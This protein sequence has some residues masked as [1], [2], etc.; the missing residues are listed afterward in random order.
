MTERQQSI[1]SISSILGWIAY[2]GLF[3]YF[4]ISYSWLY[5]VLGFIF[6]AISTGI[7]VTMFPIVLVISRLWPILFFL[8]S[9]IEF[10]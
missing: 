5:T 2:T 3:I 6:T 8:I 7:L 4:G 10:F 1:L 9:Y